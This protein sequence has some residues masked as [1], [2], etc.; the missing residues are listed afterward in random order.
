[1]GALIDFL[2]ANFKG[3]SAGTPFMDGGMLPYWVDSVN[4][5]DGVMSAIYGLNTS[6]LCTGTADSKW[7][8]DSSF[9][10]TTSTEA[11]SHIHCDAQAES[12]PIFFLEQRH[13]A[14]NLAIGLA[15]Q[16]M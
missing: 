2:R 6:R 13:L 16:A 9:A 15:S 4:G 8:Y 10:M 7:A 3:A 12:S 1:M 5:T 14:V 11:I